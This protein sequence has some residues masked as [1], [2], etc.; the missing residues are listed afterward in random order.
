[1]HWQVCCLCAWILL[2]GLAGAQTQTQFRNVSLDDRDPSI[3]Y[4][5]RSSWT[6]T[7]QDILDS[8][9]GFMLTT[10]PSAYA[11][12]KF[13]GVALYYW[14]APWQTEQEDVATSISIDG[15]P[16]F[17]VRL[18]R[19]QTTQIPNPNLQIMASF[20]DLPNAEHTVRVDPAPPMNYAVVDFFVYTENVE[21]DQ[22]DNGS[23]SSSSSPTP[24]PPIQDPTGSTDIS[25]SFS[26]NEAQT[27][28]GAA[29]PSHSSTAQNKAQPKSALS[30]GAIV[31]TAF[32][33]I[34]CLTLILAIVFLFRRFRRKSGKGVVDMSQDLEDPPDTR[35]GAHHDF[36]SVSSTTLP[37][38]LHYPTLSHSAGTGYPTRAVGQAHPASGY[39]GSGSSRKVDGFGNL[40]PPPYVA[41]WAK[42]HTSGIG[43]SLDNTTVH[44]EGKHSKTQF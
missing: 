7:A 4:E 22:G 19:T 8:G 26:T 43:G 27:G 41:A 11:E 16:P 13:T 30:T 35:Y 1:M 24:S 39:Y 28:I 12:F 17:I 38:P 37:H 25:G 10:E 29:S 21:D 6:L 9:R 15:G 14:A 40:Q 33:I 42:H 3:L 20:V 18:R 44:R 5:P 23:S 36:A 31:G 34:F 2:A 32:G